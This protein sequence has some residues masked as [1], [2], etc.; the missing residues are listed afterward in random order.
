MQ[1]VKD[2]KFHNFESFV[3]SISVIEGNLIKFH[4]FYVVN[5]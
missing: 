1:V 5:A 4:N 2:S 3:M